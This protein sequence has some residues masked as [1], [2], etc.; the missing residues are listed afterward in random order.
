MARTTCNRECEIGQS[1]LRAGLECRSDRPRC[2]RP[3]GG[4]DL[5]LHLMIGRSL[6]RT[7]TDQDRSLA[8]A[9]LRSLDKSIK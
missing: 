3:Q 9:F 8:S 2:R 4:Q 5:L 1:L 7:V 6:G